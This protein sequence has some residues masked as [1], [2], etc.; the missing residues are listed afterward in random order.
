MRLLA[1]CTSDE[2]QSCSE[3]N[4]GRAPSRV[5][6]SF[7]KLSH[8]SQHF[9]FPLNSEAKQTAYRLKKKK[10]SKEREII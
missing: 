1:I 7:Q 4:N 6:T 10:H 3:G 5:Y 9:Q 8:K 2:V